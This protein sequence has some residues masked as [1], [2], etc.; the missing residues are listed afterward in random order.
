[1][2]NSSRLLLTFCSTL[3]TVLTC[4]IAFSIFAGCGRYGP[5]LPPEKLSPREVSSLV[6]TPTERTLEL[7]WRAPERDQRGKEL[8]QIDGYR[9]YRKEIV[10][11]SDITDNTIDETLIADIRDSHIIERE[12][13]RKE[14]RA[15]GKPGRK[16]DAPDE[17]KVFKYTETPPELGRSYLYT[18]IPY[19]QGDIEGE[20]RLQ[21]VVTWKG[22]QSSLQAIATEV[23]GGEA[24]STLSLR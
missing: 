18:V 11:S 12:R 8:K 15:E 22:T 2:T 3:C 9:I 7:S 6:V 13:L 1:M 5:P 20:V 17:M 14:A 10:K 4:S 21:Y 24:A 23:D 19:N 16:L